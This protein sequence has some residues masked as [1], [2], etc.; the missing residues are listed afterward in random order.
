[1]IDLKLILVRQSYWSLLGIYCNSKY[2]IF[3]S[4]YLLDCVQHH[5]YS[6]NLL[7]HCMVFITYY[8]TRRTSQL[9]QSLSQ[10]L[11]L[12]ATISAS[13]KTEKVE[14]PTICLTFLG[15]VLDILTMDPSISSE[16]KSPEQKSSLL[17][18]IHTFCKAK[19]ALNKSCYLSLASH[20]LH[21]KWFQQAMSVN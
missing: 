18:A 19:N 17:T 9:H 20:P 7:K 5:S 14:G 21:A 16:Q 13:I 6:I 10:V 8:I 4:V 2:Y 1:M 12:C 3:I 11:S 15:I